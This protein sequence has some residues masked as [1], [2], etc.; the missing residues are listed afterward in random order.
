MR[1]HAVRIVQ[2]DLE[3]ATA[4]VDIAKDITVQIEY[5]NLRPI[6][7]SSRRSG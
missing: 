3:C 4:D 7:S 5:W 2:N 6:S 1:L